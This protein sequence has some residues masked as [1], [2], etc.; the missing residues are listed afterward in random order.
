[1]ERQIGDPRRPVEEAHRRATVTPYSFQRTP[2]PIGPDRAILSDVIWDEYQQGGR[3]YVNNTPDGLPS[4]ECESNW[5]VTQRII[6]DDVVDAAE[7]AGLLG[8]TRQ[9]V[10]HLC[11]TGRL[12]AKRLTATWVTTRQ[13]VTAYSLARRSPGRPRADQTEGRLQ[14]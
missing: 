13:A 10:V 4:T 8:V 1:M 2:A 6:L 7:A 5:D 12:P 3:T 11:K 14:S 9:H